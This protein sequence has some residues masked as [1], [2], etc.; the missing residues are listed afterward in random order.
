MH[1]T[2]FISFKSE[3]HIFFSLSGP[4]KEKV[5]R[6]MHYKST[7]TYNTCANR[8][9]RMD[10]AEQEII[11]LRGE[12][13]ALRSD[14][15]KLEALVTSLLVTQNQPPTSPLNLQVIQHETSFVKMV[16]S[17]FQGLSLGNKK[18][19][20]NVTSISSLKDA[21]KVIQSGLST[22]W[23]QDVTLPENNHREGLGFYPTPAK[24]VGP[25]VAIKTLEEI[26]HSAGFIYP[27]SSSAS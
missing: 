17:Q 5:A 16:L 18:A 8:K 24:A 19:K 4:V 11:E 2:A 26:F 25:N 27:S 20:E 6:P 21:Q 9:R 15:E 3:S 10:L 13:I 14:L 7:H 22:G 12:V 1:H 23:G